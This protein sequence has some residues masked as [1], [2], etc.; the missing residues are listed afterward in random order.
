MYLFG[1]DR[2]LLC[3]RGAVQQIV[4]TV[5]N[6]GPA[7][8]EAGPKSSKFAVSMSGQYYGWT[9]VYNGFDYLLHC[10]MLGNGAVRLSE[11]V[12]RQYPGGLSQSLAENY[13]L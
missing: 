10:T 12:R 13:R 3:Q 5:I 4:E 2:S 7:I 6:H 8:V 11:L 9:V 1:S